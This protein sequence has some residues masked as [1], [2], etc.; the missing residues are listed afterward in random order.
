MDEAAGTCYAAGPEA[1]ADGEGDV[2]GGADVQD[3][4][5]VHKGEVLGVVQQAQLRQ[6]GTPAAASAMLQPYAYGR[7]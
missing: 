6:Q 7:K 5:P 3:L 2:V 1:V 4:V